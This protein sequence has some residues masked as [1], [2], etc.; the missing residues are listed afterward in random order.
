MRYHVRRRG[1]SAANLCDALAHLRRL[2]LDGRWA[3]AEAFAAPEDDKSSHP[4]VDLDAVRAHVRTQAFLELLDDASLETAAAP[5]PDALVAAL[6]RLREVCDDEDADAEETRVGAYGE[7]TPCF[8]VIKRRAP[9]FR[10][11]CAVLALGDVRAHPPLRAWTKARGRLET[12]EAV[13]SALAPLYP[14]S[15]AN[16]FDGADGVEIQTS[17]PARSNSRYG[18]PSRTRRETMETLPYRCVR[19]WGSSS[20]TFRSSGR[21]KASSRSNAAKTYR[22][23]TTR[24]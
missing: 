5:D 1:G 11:A 15:D 9:T 3:E 10:D 17:D 4:S 19:R 12:F 20:A 13:K 6:E 8:A 22:T 21:A 16:A 2:V 7:A 23:R 24:R 14:E 18:E